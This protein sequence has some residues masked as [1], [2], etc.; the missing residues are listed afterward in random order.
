MLDEYFD[1]VAGRVVCGEDEEGYNRYRVEDKSLE[2]IGREE[3]RTR[4]YSIEED[5]GIVEVGEEERE[6]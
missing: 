3:E 6:I 5:I 4:G 2:S 1:G